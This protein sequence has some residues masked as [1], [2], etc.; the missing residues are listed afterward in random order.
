MEVTHPLSVEHSAETSLPSS[1]SVRSY[2]RPPG[3]Y[4]LSMGLLLLV[5]LF[6]NFYHLG[7]NGY[8]NVYYADGVKSM[9]MNWHNF[10][11]VSYDPGGFITIDKPP[12]S[13]WVQ[14]LSARIFGLSPWSVMLPQALAGVLSVPLLAYL[15]R[16]SYGPA[17]GLLAG[18][19]LVLMPISVATNRNMT[20]DSLL[21]LVLLLAAWASLVASERGSLRLLMLSMVLVGVGFN[22]K[23]LEA[24]LILPAF[25]LLYWFAAPLPPRK[26]LWHLMVAVVPLLL[27]SLCWATIVDLTP[28]TQRPFVGSS[29]SNSELQLA[30][31]YN[32]A[33]R[34]SGTINFSFQWLFPSKAMI[35]AQNAVPPFVLVTYTV[36]NPGLLRLMQPPLG[37]QI[38]WLLPLAVLGLVGVKWDKPSFWPLNRE[39]SGLALWGGWFLAGFVF[40]SSASFMHQYYT[41]VLSP[42]LCALLAI[43]IVTTWRDT[44]SRWRR[45][46]LPVGL[47][48][49]LLVQLNLL[50][51]HRDILWGLLLPLV[52]LS[53]LLLV[54]LLVWRPM[55]PLRP[56]TRRIL[57][58]VACTV[59]AL[60]PTIWT[61]IPVLNDRTT[62]FPFA[63]PDVPVSHLQALI[64]HTDAEITPDAAAI[65]YLLQHQGHAH[66]LVASTNS[67]L[68]GPIILATGKPVITINGYDGADQILTPQ[69]LRQYVLSGAVRY[70][71]L[72]QT[73]DESR[74]H[75]DPAVL[76]Y[77]KN[78]QT[79]EAF[80]IM[81][82]VRPATDWVRTQCR[83]VPTA[84]WHP[85]LAHTDPVTLLD[86]YDCSALV[87][88]TA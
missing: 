29:A 28:A 24:Y 56:T 42:A 76:T 61:L 41:V 30:L 31:L 78:L 86:L 15:V 67:W 49:T 58:G 66:Y 10:F 39:Q 52:G 14:V 35:A 62:A 57:I 79:L 59:L 74:S 7:Q 2:R 65:Q 84:A 53:I 38:G 75:I 16:R 47:L 77:Q 63:G 45:W 44:S 48:A 46:F 25:G 73:F 88:P 11:F 20:M 1:E 17:A 69:Q 54:Y 36:G 80:T 23:M 64:A 33:S 22:I 9:L 51:V 82:N 68:T 37:E 8:G 4:L 34:L 60:A 13:F 50:F 43:G 40:F 55:Q 12:V 87:Q 21:T 5:S 85:P 81:A 6:L 26:R 32:G 83:L 27:V 72:P 70:F 19:A 71:I 18:A 3:W